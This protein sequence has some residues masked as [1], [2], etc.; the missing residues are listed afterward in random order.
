MAEILSRGV[1]PRKGFPSVVTS[2]DKPP[3][4]MRQFAFGFA[5][6]QASKGGDT[7][8][9]LVLRASFTRYLSGQ[10]PTSYSRSCL[11]LH[12]RMQ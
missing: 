2:T 5:I 9:Q 8:R 6:D 11:E 7:A 12:S 4:R 10:C 1:N 3:L